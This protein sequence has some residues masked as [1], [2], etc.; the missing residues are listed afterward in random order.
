MQVRF[1]KLKDRVTEQYKEITTLEILV[2]QVQVIEKEYKK[3]VFRVF[4]KL[5]LVTTILQRILRL[6]FN[7][8]ITNLTIQ[9][10][11]M[12]AYDTSI[13]DGNIEAYQMIITIERRV[14]MKNRLYSKYWAL[15]TPRS[16]KAIIL[17]DIMNIIKEK[18]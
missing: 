10:K 8:E 11:A 15:N 2:D 14:L 6:L 1:Y 4:E 12:T 13:K 18:A 5:D 7:Q 3:K 17:L 16:A 9:N